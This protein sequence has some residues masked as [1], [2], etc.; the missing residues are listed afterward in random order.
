MMS[1]PG[2]VLV[3]SPQ[4]R[5]PSFL[6]TVVYVVDHGANG[7]LGFIVNRPLDVPLAD[8]WEAVPQRLRDARIA[9]IGGPVDR[10]KGLLLHG[11]LDIPDAQLMT[12]QIAVG[13]SVPALVAHYADGADASGPRLFL[14]HSGWSPGQLDREL[15]E[16]AWLVRPGKIAWLL[17]PVPVAN[18]WQQLIDG[19]VGLPDPSLN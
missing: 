11:A 10:D 5:E 1:L 16:G 18:L 2:S 12:P 14:G 4:L 6:Q 15:E 9:A 7:T 19:R 8:L 17:N 3:A 13:G